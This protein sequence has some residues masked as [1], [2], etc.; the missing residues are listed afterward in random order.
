MNEILNFRHRFK[1][2]DWIKKSKL[3]WNGLCK[4]PP[5]GGQHRELTS[6]IL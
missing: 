1:L 6:S 2:K 4:F 5:C 3:D